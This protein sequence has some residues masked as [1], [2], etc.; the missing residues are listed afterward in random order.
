MIPQNRMGVP[1][2]KNH[3]PYSIPK[4]VYRQDAGWPFSPVSASRL[5]GHRFTVSKRGVRFNV[6]PIE[7][8]G[9]AAEYLAGPDISCLEQLRTFQAASNSSAV[10][11]T[12]RLLQHLGNANGLQRHWL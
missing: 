7:P 5:E 6:V 12:V 4:L 2:M 3:C 8:S 11:N 10:V 9:T 1:S